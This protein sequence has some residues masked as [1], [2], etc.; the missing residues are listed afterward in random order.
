MV[1]TVEGDCRTRGGTAS[2]Y[3]SP[4][5][6]SGKRAQRLL[7]LTTRAPVKLAP[8]HLGHLHLGGTQMAFLPGAAIDV[9]LTAMSIIA[10]SPAHDL[11]QVF[12]PHGVDPPA[13][14]SLLH[15]HN[16]VFPDGIELT[17]TEL[18]PRPIGRDVVP[19][20]N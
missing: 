12:G 18:L 14:C 3:G 11:R 13:L 4:S 15:Q 19:E 8:T 7:R 1:A 20:K 17:S 2:F 10:R 6:A 9:H 5:L 16:E